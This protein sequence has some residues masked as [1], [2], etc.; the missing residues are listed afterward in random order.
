VMDLFT[1]TERATP[2]PV[3]QGPA[4]PDQITLAEARGLELIDVAPGNGWSD[5][6]AI[7][8]TECG[9]MTRLA[10]AATWHDFHGIELELDSAQIATVETWWKEVTQ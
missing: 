3:K 1:W 2:A 6:Y 10:H 5:R 9:S 8:A 4:R 7:R